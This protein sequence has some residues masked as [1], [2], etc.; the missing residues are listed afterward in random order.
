MIEKCSRTEWV[1][2]DK[3]ATGSRSSC[4]GQAHVSILNWLINWTL[5]RAMSFWSARKHLFQFIREVLR[6][7]WGSFLMSGRKS[8]LTANIP[9]SK[10]LWRDSGKSK[11]SE[12]GDS[13]AKSAN[14]HSWARWI[15]P[16]WD[17]RATEAFRWCS[18]DGKTLS[19]KFFSCR[20]DWKEV[21]HF[22]FSS[23]KD[24]KFPKWLRT[25]RHKMGRNWC[26]SDN[27][28]RKRREFDV[29]VNRK[30]RERF[31]I[32]GKSVRKIDESKYLFCYEFS[33][34]RKAHGNRFWQR[35]TS[36]PWKLCCALI[37]ILHRERWKIYSLHNRKGELRDREKFLAWSLTFL[38]GWLL[39][40]RNLEK[41]NFAALLRSQQTFHRTEIATTRPTQHA[42][43][44]RRQRTTRSDVDLRV[45]EN[46]LGEGN[47]ARE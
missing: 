38:T 25:L 2:R 16:Q 22:Q 41:S 9:E 46:P 20:R 13:C 21:F 3:W 8:V 36:N 1:D 39:T 10:R 15:F 35:M 28:W 29:R 47:S 32:S 26:D 18:W 27:R 7:R 30:C 5:C 6:A 19:R 4:I 11:Q 17:F 24:W 33:T 37:R 14:E 23:R 12:S 45:R 34:R 42:L 31:L 40:E 44:I 43:Q